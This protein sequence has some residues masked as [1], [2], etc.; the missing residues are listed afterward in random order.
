MRCVACNKQ[1]NEFESTR[2][3]SAG[4]FIDLCNHC[5]KAGDYSFETNDRLDLQSDSDDITEST[6]ELNS[7]VL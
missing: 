1:L 3:D 5:F 2:K 6:E 4:G 7:N